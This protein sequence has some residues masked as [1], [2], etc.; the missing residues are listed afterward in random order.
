MEAKNK[1][2]EFPGESRKERYEDEGVKGNDQNA[3]IRS[4]DR[5][6]VPG[7][8]EHSER[9]KAE[10]NADRGINEYIPDCM[11]LSENGKEKHYDRAQ[12]EFREDEELR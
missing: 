5:M 8:A 2:G 6:Q 7:H 9:G 10:F 3:A 1:A 11:N 12:T 4:E